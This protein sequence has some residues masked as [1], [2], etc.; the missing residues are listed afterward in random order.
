MGE[1]IGLKQILWEP[2]SVGREFVWK[3]LKNAQ[4]SN[5]LNQNPPIPIK[6]CLDVDHGDISSLNSDDYNPYKWLGKIL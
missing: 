3:L 1:K 4:T 5:E 6:I 2:M